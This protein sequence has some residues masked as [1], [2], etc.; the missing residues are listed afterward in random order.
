MSRLSHAEKLVN[1][2][3]NGFI[4]EINTARLYWLYNEMKVGHEL[5][6]QQK[7]HIIVA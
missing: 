6:Q 4:N 3:R 1:I 7:I 2:F 5:P